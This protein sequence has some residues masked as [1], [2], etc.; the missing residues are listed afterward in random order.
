MLPC[1]LRYAALPVSEWAARV[2]L[3]SSA[4]V[5]SLTLQC[6]V[7]C[8]ILNA[9]R[10]R[11]RSERGLLALIS[12]SAACACFSEKVCT[13][14]LCVGGFLRGHT[15]HSICHYF[16]NLL[17]E[18]VC[19]FTGAAIHT[20]CYTFCGNALSLHE[21]FDCVLCCS[22]HVLHS[23]EFPCPRLAFTVGF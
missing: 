11:G 9:T 4:S 17:F 23:Y 21:V 16:Q 7:V 14:C 12:N 13:N 1:L 2:Q 19:K 18:L 3:A 5:R 20:G 22:I 10:T 15:L 8:Q 6:R